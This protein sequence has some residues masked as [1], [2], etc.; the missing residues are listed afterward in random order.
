MKRKII[1]DCDNTFGV[2][3]CDVDD[4]LAII[5]ALADEHTD[6][7]GVT[8]TFGN[9]TLDVVYPNTVKFMRDIGREEI[10]V[11]KGAVKSCVENEA[12]KFM[13]DTANKYESEISIIATGSLTNLHHAWQIDND[14]YKKIDKLY[15]MGGITE[16]LIINGKRLNE[17]NFSCNCE[18]SLNVFKHARNITVA[19][20]NACLPAFFTVERFEQLKDGNEFEK[21]LYDSCGYW[22]KR[23]KA[24]FE[25]DGIYI[26]DIL[27]VVPLTAPQLVIEE[28]VIISPDGN[29][30]RTGLLFGEGEKREITIPKIINQEDYIEYIYKSFNKYEK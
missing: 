30:M 13:V 23:E 27:A 20:G 5:Y 15:L 26:W 11:L 16:P 6:L 29:G 17:L 4:G 25:N 3:G 12:A 7:L 19:T 9:N 24:V 1:F 22:F 8:T 10:P 28:K 2:D 21:W 18:A 14:F